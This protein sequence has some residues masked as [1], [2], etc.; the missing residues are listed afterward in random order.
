[1]STGTFFRR[2][3]VLLALALC[4]VGGVVTLLGR[5]A[6]GPQV[7]QKRVPLS[8]EPGTKA[9]PAFSPDG[10]RVAYSVRG[11]GKGDAFHIYVRAAGADTPRQ[12]TQGD[13]NDVSPAWSPDGDRIAFLRA[14]DGKVRYIIVPAGGGA[15]R[16]VAEFPLA[17]DE[18]RPAPAVAWTRDGKSLV[19]V[20]GSDAQPPALAIVAAES[21]QATRI[22]NPPKDSGGDSTPVV[23]PDGGTLAFVRATSAEG[24]DVFLCDISGANPR[25]LT[26]D[27]RSIRG[28]AWTPDGHDIVYSANRVGKWRLWRLPVYGGSPHELSIA[29]EAAEY[30]AIAPEGH[31]MAFADSPSVSAIWRG[32][33][34]K[35]D[36][37]PEERPVI[38]SSG[39]EVSPAYSPDGKR[40]ADISGQSGNDEIWISGADGENREQV[41]SLKGPPITRVRWSPDGKSLLFDARGERGSDL[42]TVPAAAGAKAARIVLGASNASWSNDGKRIYFSSRG[43]L[44]KAAPNGGSPE[45]LL[46]DMGFSQPVESPDGKYVYFRAQRGFFRVPV[47]GGEAE[48]AISPEHDLAWATTLQFTKKGAYYAELQHSTRS[49]L[50]SFYDFGTKKNSVVYRLKGLEFGFGHLFS[51]SPDGKYVLYPRVDRSQTDLMLVQNFR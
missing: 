4:T 29:G 1:M 38:R 11:V 17:G 46:D 30:P 33:L 44:W 28:I 50:I 41:T 19:V 49:W 20:Q 31:K 14:E 43:R 21:G 7:E 9:Y 25:K 45:Q 51:I 34:G 2:P 3:A 8:N 22:T 35:P 13:A 6:S 24:G 15:E 18:T 47:A 16:Q 23:S 26:F 42:Y 37:D 10:Q 5:L 27:D 12:L 40:I 39:R 36:G 48:E 32:T